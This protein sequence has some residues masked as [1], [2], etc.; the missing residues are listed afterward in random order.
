MS[1][2]YQGRKLGTGKEGELR[3]ELFGRAV[4]RLSLSITHSVS[5][6]GSGSIITNEINIHR[7]G[8]RRLLVTTTGLTSGTARL[9]SLVKAEV[10]LQ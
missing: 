8:R 9:Q 4:V 7:D 5:T 2:A 3:D 10:L 1:Q 6:L